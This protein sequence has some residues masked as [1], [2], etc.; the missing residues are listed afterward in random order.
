MD[1]ITNSNDATFKKEVLESKSPVVVDFYADWC[2]PC[3]SL[4]P[5]FEALSVDYSGK[6]KFV[7]VNVDENA[8]ASEYGVSSIPTTIFFSKGKPIDGIIGVSTARE[9]KKRLDKIIK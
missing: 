7:K 4:A 9:Y 5:I 8:V 3:K 2:G 6:I 1:M